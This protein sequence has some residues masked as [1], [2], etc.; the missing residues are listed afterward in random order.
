MVGYRTKPGLIKKNGYKP[1]K[2]PRNKLFRQVLRF[3]DILK[4]KF[5]IVENVPG[6]NTLKIKYRNGHHNIISLLERGLKK[7]GYNFQTNIIDAKEFGVPQNRK[8]IFCIARKHMRLPESIIEEM[9]KTAAG[10]GRK[11]RNISL[12]AAIDK[13]PVL[14]ANEGNEFIK[15]EPLAI[16][17]KNIY[18]KFIGDRKKL[19]YSH[20]SRYHND[21]DMKI[22]RELKQG[23]NFRRLL[24]RAP[25][26]IEGRKRKVYSI[27]NFP[28][29]YFR[30]T[31]NT[32]S[33]TIVSHLSKDGNSFIHPVQN[34]SLS[35]REA[36]RE[37][38][39]LSL[40]R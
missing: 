2:D 23:E 40:F 37:A 7:R 13:L 14:E 3:V 17:R 9:K 6:I 10:M 15:A 39:L 31:W 4:P 12:Q 34:R 27:N 26:T 19:L 28:D 38:G 1:E 8:R 24:E 32:P 22:I 11:R 35:I 29:K 25:Q 33:R 21:D 16:D 36:A 5:V 18:G 30:L 20:F